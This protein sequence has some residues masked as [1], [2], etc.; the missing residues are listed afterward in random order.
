MPSATLSTDLERRKQVRV[1]LRG[2][3]SITPQRYEGRTYYIVKDPVSLRYW[4]FKDKEYFLIQL[5]DGAVTLDEAQK[6]FEKRFRPERLPLEELESFAQQLVNSGLAHNDSPN[7]GKHLFDRRKKRLRSE[8]MQV[9]TNILYIK[10]PV[11]D[12]DKTLTRMLP[13]LRWIYTYWFMGVSIAVMLAAVALV[14]THFEAFRD[15]LPSYHEFF[16]F[17]NLTYMW[18]ALGAVKIIHEFGHG[19][20]C[21]AFGGETHE[22]G[23]LFLCLSPCLYCNVSDSWTLPNKWKRIIISFAGIYVE[24][25]IAALST[26]V[27]W[28]SAGQPFVNHMA[29]SLMVVCS[30]STVVFNANPLMRYDGYYILADWIEIPNLRDRSNR[31]LSTAVQEHCLGIEVQPEPHMELSRRILFVTYAI[32][33]YIYR[34][35]VTFSI[36]YFLSKFLEPYKLRAVSN[37]LAVAAAGSMV[38]WPLFRLGKSLHKRGRL[39]DMKPKRVSASTAVLAAVILFLFL[40]P[41]PVSRVRQI[42]V[43]EVAPTEAAKM[44]LMVPGS[45]LKAVYVRDGQHVEEGDL[46]AEFTNLEVE[47]K[48]HQAR[49]EANIHEAELKAAQSKLQ[50]TKDQGERSK[51]LSEI[52]KAKSD[53]NQARAEAQGYEKMMELLV[54]KAPRTGVVMSPPRIDDVGKQWD[55][56]HTTPICTVGDPHHLWVLVPVSTSDYNLLKEDLIHARG[57]GKDL[58]VDLRVHGMVEKTWKGSIAQLPESEAK[59]VPMA[60]TLKAGGPVAV[61]PAAQPNT[62]VPQTQQYLVAVEIQNPGDAVCPGAFAQVKIHCRWRTC[63][64]WAWRTIS[65]TFDLGLL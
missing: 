58:S 52:A 16:S 24:L 43:I 42:G 23:V 4:R 7:V 1:R 18:F 36:L 32:V 56:E 25:I 27:W 6:E 61:K 8:W 11:F 62:Y 29:L 21:K 59:E 57:K 19:L 33:S 53:R 5:M 28:N 64:W 30:V 55:K 35:V 54:L 40:M 50:E 26:F 44:H 37:L 63:V 20:S 39:P 46:L 38:G 60:L 3:L 9:L 41:L 14:L 34:W 2:D 49:T 31:F 48:L 15:K 65:S 12:P 13:Y 22:M 51:L 47:S 17:K 45:I 10:I